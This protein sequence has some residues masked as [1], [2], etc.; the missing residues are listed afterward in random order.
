MPIEEQWQVSTGETIDQLV[1]TDVRLGGMDGF[2]NLMHDLYRAAREEEGEP[3]TYAAAKALKR[4]VDFLDNVLIVTGAGMRPWL[5]HGETDGPPGTV[6][7]AHG[8][9]RALRARPVLAVEGRSMEALVAASHGMGL[10]D[11]P[12]E[13]L[14][15]RYNAVSVVEYPEGRDAAD[16]AAE[17]FIETYDPSAI[18]AVERMGSNRHGE[19]KVH[20][21]GYEGYDYVEGNAVVGPLFEK[22]REEGILTIGIGDRGN[23]TG[24]GKIEEEV[25]DIYA[26]AGKEDIA[27]AVETDHLITAGTSNWGAYGIEA[28]LSILTETPEAMHGPDDESRVLD[29]H[30]RAGSIDAVSNLARKTV[31]GTAEKTQRGMV[32]IL[33]NIV[34]NRLT[35]HVGMRRKVRGAEE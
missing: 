3:L 31:D 26:D 12:F 23:E 9:A 16:A 1:S 34:E 7:L 32:G 27:C 22:A 14:E 15:H 5:P 30:S 21:G 19:M 4:E 8:L 24:F 18:V 2:P 25:R 6:G 11:V 10:L 35:E 20:E 13:D 17:E 28:M 29:H 33:Q